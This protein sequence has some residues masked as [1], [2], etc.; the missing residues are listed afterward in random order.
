MKI[1]LLIVDDVE[2]NL[3][4]LEVLLEELEIEDE[5]FDGL[6]IIKALNGEE[7][8]RV[9]IKESIDLILLDVRMP[10]M[11]G[12]EVAKIL[13]SSIKTS[14]IPI[15]FVTAEFKSEDFINNGYKVGALDYFTKP[16]EKFQ[17]LNKIQLYITL[18]LSK[19][20]QKKEF[21]ETLYDYMNLIDK[22]IISS[23]TDMFGN[24]TRVS[25]AFCDISG[26]SKED[27]IG[28]T[29]SIIRSPDV[30]NKFYE[31]MWDVLSS[32]ETWKGKIKN[33]TKNDE[34]YWVDA[35]IS[36]TY[37]SRGKKVGYTSIKE[38]IT[39][40]KRLEDISI[41]DELTAIYNRR[42]FNEMMP[43]IINS[44]KRYNRLICFAMIDI[45]YFKRYN[46]TYGHQAGDDVLKKV[47]KVFKISTHRADDYCF[48][49]GGEE[50]GIVFGAENEENALQ[51]ITKIKDDIEALKI[52]NIKSD[53][54]KYLTVS[55]GLTCKKG[56]EINSLETLY[57]Q[58]DK[59]LYLA[60]ENGRNRVVASA[61]EEPILKNIINQ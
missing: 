56:Q 17:F 1:N 48:R 27:F 59:L 31:N 32:N 14:Q 33:R 51:F 29:H 45:D 21:D 23:D 12:F 15:I 24:I 3:Y 4:A 30:D 20:V 16:I 11:D 2:E 54:G 8:L 46:D 36:P 58:T 50:F 37:D 40:K 19:K 55:I 49:V 5:H 52:E 9:A 60:K 10:G 41:T 39:S 7:A 6:N 26:Y 57:S 44:S 22:Y 18:F 38:D 47:A 42:F 43:K 34:Y 25:Q 35:V 13:K 53:V 28:N 61:N